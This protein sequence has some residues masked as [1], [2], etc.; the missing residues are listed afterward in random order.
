MFKA[1]AIVIAVVAI[2]SIAVVYV[3]ST[4]V[5]DGMNSEMSETVEEMD[6]VTFPVSEVREFTI[7]GQ[8]FSFAPASIA[9]NE[10][11]R[12]R[13][14]FK[15]ASGFHDL[16]IDEFAVATKQI[17]GGQEEVVEFVANKKGTFEYYCSVGNHRAM[18]MTGSL[19][20]Q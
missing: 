12:V 8:N 10:G 7:S 14:T 19:I 6:N 2:V 17:Q 1:I 9:V 3:N 18:G 13:I 20:V 16:K 4:K 5:D 11:D 15:N